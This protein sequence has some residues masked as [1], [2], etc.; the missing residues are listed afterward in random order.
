FFHQLV[1]RM[2]ALPGV[3]SASYASAP[4]LSFNLSRTVLLEGGNENDRTMIDVNT[5]GPRYLETMGIP[6]TE[7]RSLNEDDKQG[8][9][10]AVV[11][12]Q[13]MA[14]K[15]WPK[16]DAL[17]KRFRFFGA[18]EPWAEIVGIAKDAKYTFLGEDPRS[19][20]YEAHAQRYSGARTLLVRTASDPRPLLVP[21]ERELK[22]MD[23]DLP[24]QALATISTSLNDSFGLQ[25][26]RA[27]ASL[28]GLFGM[29]ALVLAAVGIYSVMSYFVSQRQREIGIRMALGARR[30]DVLRMI[31]GRGM[32]VVGV[33]LALG[34]VIS[35]ALSRLAANMLVGVSP[36]DLASFAGAAVV[37]AAVAFIANVFPTRRAAG[38]DPIVALRYQ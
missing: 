26:Q 25:A 35:L 12:N 28:L 18:D 10:K 9:P 2:G 31:L 21:V 6:L 27:G 20:I 34:L 36:W 33:G 17:G 19:Y 37:L 4:P 5:V 29:L 15:F 22:T 13:T 30:V 14:K 16:G 24:L 32:G 3:V 8:G 11:I 23:R 38:I 1:E 7:G